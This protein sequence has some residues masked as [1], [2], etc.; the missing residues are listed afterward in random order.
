MTLERRRRHGPDDVPMPE[1]T[2]PAYVAIK[3]AIEATGM[4][5]AQ[6]QDV[7]ERELRLRGAAELLYDTL[8]GLGRMEGLPLTK[9]EIA[10]KLDELR[11]KEEAAANRISSFGE[12][13]MLA[14][15]E[16]RA[17]AFNEAI[18][19]VQG[20]INTERRMFPNKKEG[21]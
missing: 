16:N 6:G 9:L 18:M 1:P 14:R 5:W 3:A 19:V 15:H 7:P 11:K 20:F 12:Q 2:D 10:N 17:N 8:V 4:S 21:S 13:E